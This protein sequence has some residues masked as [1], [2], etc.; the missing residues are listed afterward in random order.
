MEERHSIL[1]SDPEG[2]ICAF[3][4]SPPAPLGSDALHEIGVGKPAWLHFNWTDARARN[5]LKDQ[6]NL[7]ALAI[8]SLLEVDPHAHLQLLP[9]AFV[10]VLRD[11]N[12]EFSSTELHFGTLGIYLDRWRVISG[13]RQPLHTLDQMRR[14]LLDGLDLESPMGWFEHLV[15]RLA[16]TYD[17]VVVKI[18]STLETTEDEILAGRFGDQGG[19]LRRMRWQ[20]A[21]L[22]RHAL[23]NR[24][25][26]LRLPG[27]LPH[28]CGPERR[29]SL[30]LAID[31]FASVAQDLE[32]AEERARLLQEEIAARLSEAT[33]KNLYLLSIVTT[34]MLPVTL[35]TGVFG[36][37]VGGLPWLEDPHGF[38]AVIFLM[39]IAL[40]VS[41]VLIGK[42]RPQ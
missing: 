41:L 2:L 11:V 33:N 26:L 27:H 32:L 31:G 6:G 34:A 18:T 28:F 29:Q 16:E 5:W 7:P 19:E 35:I 22:R 10:A 40:L 38:G 23:S 1:L 24:S 36:M 30:A 3:L 21:R 17:S 39:L 13:R 42:T 9:D 12:H 4:L 15:E 25:T 14:E 8:E 20:L 37:N